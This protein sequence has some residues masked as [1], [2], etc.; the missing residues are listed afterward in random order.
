[1]PR[2]D[3]T[4]NAKEHAHAAGVLMERTS[5][6]EQIPDQVDAI[7]TALNANTHALLALVCLGQA[8]LGRRS[9]P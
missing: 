5:D 7:V 4:P 8:E 3:G 2:L 6:P 9:D 1:M